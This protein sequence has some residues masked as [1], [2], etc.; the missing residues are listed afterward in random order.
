MKKSR[1]PLKKKRFT[2]RMKSMQLQP[3]KSPI[4]YQD[5]TSFKQQLK[6]GVGYGV[7]FELSDFLMEGIGNGVKRMFDN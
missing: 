3:I 6:T 5:K 1:K 2:R 7:G 4:Q